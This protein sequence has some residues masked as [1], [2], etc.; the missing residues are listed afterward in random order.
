[1][2]WIE[3]IP[4]EFAGFLNLFICK[5]NC[6]MIA[7]LYALSLEGIHF[8]FGKFLKNIS[9]ILEDRKKQWGR[10]WKLWKLWHQCSSSLRIIYELKLATEIK[11]VEVDPS[12]S[13]LKKCFNDAIRPSKCNNNLIVVKYQKGKISHCL[14]SKKTTDGFDI[15]DPQNFERWPIPADNI[16]GI[17]EIL[18]FQ[19]NLE[20]AKKYHTYCGQEYCSVEA[21]RDVE[22]NIKLLS[23]FC[24]EM[25]NEI[26]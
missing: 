3:K 5:S 20:E 11:K 6:S 24:E 15:I 8:C 12:E 13:N 22:E 14:V 10:Q 16:S 25:S 1:M 7:L 17:K 26:V 9:G 4:V 18:C 23:N 21:N 2:S 19:P